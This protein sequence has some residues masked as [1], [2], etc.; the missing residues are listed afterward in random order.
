MASPSSIGAAMTRLASHF[1]VPRSEVELAIVSADWKEGL[2]RF[3][4]EILARAVDSWILEYDRHPTL[5]QIVEACL[6]ETR[7][8][9]RRRAEAQRDGRSH[10]P[11]REDIVNPRM[12]NRAIQVARVMKL[13][14]AKNLAEMEL[15]AAMDISALEDVKDL[16]ATRVTGIVDTLGHEHSK[17]RS[18]CPVCSRHDHS[19]PTWREDCPECGAPVPDLYEW[20]SCASCD[21][22]GWIPI[23][24]FYGPVRPCLVCNEESHRLWEGGHY[25]MNH[26]CDVCAPTRKRS[27]ET[28]GKS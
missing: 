2:A 17:G 3:P 20:S 5:N 25:A 27:R 19:A 21:G 18:G 28:E 24:G 10:L 11:P 23:D 4:D 15:R 9:V 6:V 13:A 8:I 7:L 12:A 14:P 26:R 16:F 22:S 1:R